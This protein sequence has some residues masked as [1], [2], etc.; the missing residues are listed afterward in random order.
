MPLVAVK[1]PSVAV[2]L[3]RL[4][5]VPVVLKKFVDVALVVV[6]VVI[7]DVLGVWTGAAVT[8]VTPPDMPDDGEIIPPL[9]ADAGTPDAGLPD[10]LDLIALPARPRLRG[11]SRWRS[12]AP[13]GR[14]GRVCT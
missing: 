10:G 11:F 6:P 13:A 12:A 2:V 1:L 3:K 7:V 5:K 4:V 9:V 14:A 8:P